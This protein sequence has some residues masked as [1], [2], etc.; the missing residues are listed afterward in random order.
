MNRRMGRHRFPGTCSAVD[1]SGIDG[2]T[3]LLYAVR[4]SV[5]DGEVAVRGPR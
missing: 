5:G 2:A 4:G 3:T 1:R